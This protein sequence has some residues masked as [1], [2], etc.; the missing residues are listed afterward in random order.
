[1]RIWMTTTKDHRRQIIMAITKKTVWRVIRLFLFAVVA[2]VVIFGVGFWFMLDRALCD[3]EVNQAPRLSDSKEADAVKIMWVGNS[4]T[5]TYSIPAIL[6]AFIES[7]RGVHRQTKFWQVLVPSRRLEQHIEDGLVKRIVDNNGPFDYM[8]I[9]GASTEP[10]YD[11]K[12]LIY[13]GYQLAQMAREHHEQPILF[14][15]YADQGQADNQAQV[16]KAY[17]ELAEATGAPVVPVGETWFYAVG[18]NPK[19]DLWSS[20]HHHPGPEGSYLSACVFY[21]YMFGREPTGMPAKITALNEKRKRDITIVDL[22]Q[23]KAEEL[24]RLA[25]EYYLAHKPAAPLPPAR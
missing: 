24:Q 9:Q 22:P 10:I 11:R 19:L 14:Q 5:F 6:K 3:M 12:G 23:A 7:D 18:R 21:C 4:L 8:V 13:Y 15:T 2:F 25:W 1:M 20:D 16:T 17:A